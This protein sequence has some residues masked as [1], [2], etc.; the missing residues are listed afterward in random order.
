MHAVTP[1]RDPLSEPT[2]W[3]AVA[4]D[5]DQAW[6]TRLPSLTDA[7][8]ELLSPE[9]EDTVLDIACGPGML[10]IRI[11]PRVRRVLAVDFAEVMLQHV[12]GHVMRS[13]LPNVETRVMDGQELDIEECSFDA[14]VS[15]FGVFLFADRKRGLSE[16]FRVVAPGG[17]VVISSWATPDENSLFGA[18][19]AAIRATLPDVAPPGG[20]LP[21]HTPEAC[22]EELEA[23]GFES[24]A[25]H[26]F[27]Q[28]V[29]FGS[30]AEYW[31][32]FSRGS[33]LITTLEQKLGPEAWADAS[34]R[35]QD[36]LVASLGDAAFELDCAAILSYGERPLSAA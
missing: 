12:R 33:V 34:K 22:A 21:M 25:T 27:K 26:R 16:M 13:H 23:I 20:P 32:A 24:V 36:A 8:I 30:V 1:P 2:I 10:A 11:A 3:N 28:A 4:G 19:M 29:R 7:A 9:Q 17:R 35:I 5:Y 18:G 6:F 14:A 15:L 31:Q